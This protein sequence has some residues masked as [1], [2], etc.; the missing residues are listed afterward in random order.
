MKTKNLPKQPWKKTLKKDRKFLLMCLPAIVFFLIFAY[1]PMPGIWV[2]FVR[3]DYAKGI[4]GS[5]F[6][7]LS[8]L[9][10]I[11]MSGKLGMLVRN[12]ILY[13]VGFI[14]T[15]TVMQILIAL[16]FNEL[17]NRAFR[18]YAQSF[19]I[20]PNFISYV[21]VGV[22]SFVIFNNTN[23]ILNTILKAF[24][25]SPVNVYE[26]AAAWPLIL[27]L[28]NLWK[29]S[30]YGSI[31]YFAALMGM[32]R[33][34]L[35]AAKVD[36]AT[37]IQRIRYITLP[38]LRPTIIILL[39][40]SLGGILHGNFDLFYNVVGSNNVLLQSSTD[41][42]ETFI[43][44]AMVSN[45]NFSTAAAVSFVQSVFGLIVVLATNFVVKKV[46]PDYALF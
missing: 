8:N 25:A 26:K 46:E 19:M 44:R 45:S 42:L 18:K 17:T 13:N 3:F 39:L 6:V 23:G 24:G 35:E 11:A 4:F 2:A 34:M 36:G 15:S 7:G 29:G 12:T 30:G 28:I 41:V 21:L 33:E 27:V 31:V 1:L 22:F 5:P 38:S 9:K 40:L 14:A 32:D 16:L 10:F 43:F 37:T 20:L